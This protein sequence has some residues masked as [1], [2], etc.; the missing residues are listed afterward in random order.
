MRILLLAAALIACPATCAIAKAKGNSISSFIGCKSEQQL[1]KVISSSGKLA[2]DGCRSIRIVPVKTDSGPVRHRLDRIRQGVLRTS[3]EHRADRE[4][5]GS[6][7]RSG[8]LSITTAF[9]DR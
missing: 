5:V 6:L 1:K 7:R 4:V 3:P 9:A 8:P 2:S